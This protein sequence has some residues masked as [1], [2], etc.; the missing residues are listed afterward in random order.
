MNDTNTYKYFVDFLACLNNMPGNVPDIGPHSEINIKVGTRLH[1]HFIGPHKKRV[2]SPASRI[3][4]EMSPK[5]IN[6]GLAVDKEGKR[7][8]STSGHLVKVQNVEKATRQR[9]NRFFQNKTTITRQHIH[10]PS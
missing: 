5:R 6:E 2:L 8:V 1:L 4:V 3:I 10:K 9:L 7:M